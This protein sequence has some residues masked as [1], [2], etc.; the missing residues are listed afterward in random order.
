MMDIFIDTMLK[1]LKKL[2]SNPSFIL[3]DLILYLK[4]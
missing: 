2:H 1:F 4:I 3:K